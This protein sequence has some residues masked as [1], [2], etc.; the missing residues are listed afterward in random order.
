LG[1]SSS[2]GGGGSSWG[3]TGMFSKSSSVFKE[4]LAKASQVTVSNV[5]SLMQMTKAAAAT[6]TSGGA[7]SAQGGSGAPDAGPKEG[8]F[9]YNT[10]VSSPAVSRTAPEPADSEQA[11]PAPTDTTPEKAVVKSDVSTAPSAVGG[12]GPT[13][14]KD[15]WGFFT[16][17]KPPLQA[18][19]AV[20]SVEA[21]D[22][23]EV[24]DN[25]VTPTS[26]VDVMSTEAPAVH[27]GSESGGA[28][29]NG[30]GDVSL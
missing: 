4:G 20:P 19:D 30:S 27:P 22:R 2:A 26:S 11:E 28:G 3:F 16:G 29:A 18:S 1:K 24:D 7:E 12:D 25:V 14:E 21:D 6:A 15:L 23:L 5:G 17:S 8:S 9:F 10:V 13:P